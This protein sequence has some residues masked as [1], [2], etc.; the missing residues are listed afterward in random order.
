MGARH[1]GA[2]VRAI[3]RARGLS[4]ARLAELAGVHINTVGRF[5]KDPAG[6]ETDTLER[7]GTALGVP[8]GQL[9]MAV[10]L[11]GADGH[12]SLPVLLTMAET[13]LQS[14]ARLAQAAGES[15]LTRLHFAGHGA[16]VVVASDADE[17]WLLSS[18]RRLRDE[19]RQAVRRSIRLELGEMAVERP[20]STGG[21]N[22]HAS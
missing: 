16:R 8:S 20:P 1:V 10:G 12:L 7:L 9:L 4:Q 11:L 15:D 17:E 21:G 19:A 5:E 6:A 18:W 3:R 22:K 13:G 2:V 14:A